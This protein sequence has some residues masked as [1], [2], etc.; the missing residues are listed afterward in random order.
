MRNK[1]AKNLC[2]IDEAGRGPFAGPLV[3]A[4][5]VLK[6]NIKELDDSKKLTEKKREKLFDI[7]KQNSSFHIVFKSAQQID[8]LGLS[9]CLKQSI[10]EI[11]ENIEA[12]QYL[13]D[14]N[15]TFGVEN[16]SFLVKADAQIKEVSAA[17]ILAKVSRDRF[18]VE[19]SNKYP[20]YSF[21]KHKGYGTKVHVD[22]IIKYGYC[23]IHR[24]SFKIKKIEQMRLDEP[25][26]DIF[27]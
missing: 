27:T 7:I 9:L 26:L 21:E 4:G 24:R 8:D 2:G 25:T 11:Q 3:V 5:V 6:K 10:Q 14:G 13:M 16:L 15:T 17:S 12:E 18:M 19:I 1:Y 20:Q 23:K 22:A